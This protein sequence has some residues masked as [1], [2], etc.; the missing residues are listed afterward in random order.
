MAELGLCSR[1]EADEWIANGWVRV[2]GAPAQMGM[3]VT[4][5]ARI[6]IDAKARG[7]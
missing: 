7:Q 5:E 3:Q 6:D 1:R 4:P 2:N